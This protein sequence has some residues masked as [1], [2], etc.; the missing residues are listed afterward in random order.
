LEEFHNQMY[1]AVAEWERPDDV[2]DEAEGLGPA[3][4]RFKLLDV[5]G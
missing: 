3:R 1:N 4:A 2:P 5:D